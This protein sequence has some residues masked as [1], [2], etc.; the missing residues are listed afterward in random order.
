MNI[1][2]LKKF[3]IFGLGT[4]LIGGFCL[5]ALAYSPEVTHYPLA[6]EAVNLY[7]N[8]HPENKITQQQLLWIAE[9][10]H[11]EDRPASRA[12]HHFYDPVKNQ[13]LENFKSSKEWSHDAG[14]QSLNRYQ[15]AGAS[16]GIHTWEEALSAHKRG[17]VEHAYKTLG[18]IFH[19]IQDAT[20]PAHTRQD[21]HMHVDI[22]AY[23]V[24]LYGGSD[25]FEQEAKKLKI[26]SSKNLHPI[27]LDN[28][29]AYFDYVASY[30]NNNFWSKDTVGMYDLPKITRIDDGYVYSDIA[31][32][33][34]RLARIKKPNKLFD[35]NNP[36]LDDNSFADP[37]V[38]RDYWERL[39]PL[40]IES[41]AGIIKL[42]QDSVHDEPEKSKSDF[43]GGVKN[44]FSSINT[45]IKSR[46]Q[47]TRDAFGFAFSNIQISSTPVH[48][49]N[50]VGFLS[51]GVPL[52]YEVHISQTSK[53]EQQQAQDN[54]RGQVESALKN[55]SNT[56]NKSLSTRQA[57]NRSNTSNPNQSNTSLP[58]GQAGN[59]S[60]ESN[61][62]VTRILDGDTVEL[63]TGEHVRYIGV[64]APE[65]PEGCFSKEATEFNS[66]LVLN[67][68]VELTQGPD[69]KDNFGR[70]LRYVHV[71]GESINQKLIGTGHAYAFDYGF[72]H[73]LSEEFEKIE[74]EAKKNKR[75]L[76]GEVCHPQEN[77]S[78]IEITK[79]KIGDVLGDSTQS[80]S[81]YGP[82]TGRGSNFYQDKID[83]NKASQDENNQ[84]PEIA[85]HLVINE[86]QVQDAEFVELYNPTSKDLDLST[87]YFAYYPAS[88]TTWDNPYRLKK[89]PN[90][91]AISSGGYYLV[92]FNGYPE[93]GGNPSA[94]WQP[95]SSNQLNNSGATIALFDA[96]PE[97]SDI[98]P[99]DAVGW[100]SDIRVNLK[101]AITATA[102]G[103]GKSIS[104]DQEHSDSNNNFDDFEEGNPSPKNS[105]NEKS[106]KQAEIGDT[107][108]WS[109]SQNGGE[110]SGNSLFAGPQKNPSIMW[111]AEIFGSTSKEAQPLV[112]N[113]GNTYVA[114][115]G[116]KEGDFVYSLDI[117]G[118]I[119]WQYPGKG[120]LALS[121]DSKR[122]Y[123]VDLNSVITLDTPTGAVKN[124]ATV[125]LR[126]GY[127]MA[128]D[129]KKNMVYLASKNNLY[130]INE[131][132]SVAWK[133]N[134]S[135]LDWGEISGNPNA[136]GYGHVEKVVSALTYNGDLYV[137]VWPDNG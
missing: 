76:W 5:P 109:F 129:H 48:G 4:A 120:E 81:G 24:D 44:F 100:G 130:S 117:N 54:F 79:E 23:S 59:K 26:P 114:V 110:N 20:V 21:A 50:P 16:S 69:D 121:S 123:V 11:D 57:G 136:A 15:I 70:L 119:R 97:E 102:P 35:S 60:N 51:T 133:Q 9:G 90:G 108:L 85:Q 94:D 14:L 96:N 66:S 99:I 98:K 105:S 86:I 45:G 67:R 83:Q 32:K 22:G 95:Y 37:L 38:T 36:V 103:D 25:P 74:Q 27:Y 71:E 73:K 30:S 61:V 8:N 2:K 111:K 137:V 122:L 53:S 52:D 101:E 40:G 13:G 107:P 91:A 128:T 88:R 113:A 10:A 116:A 18:H 72:T 134:W 43:I 104:R 115:R 82:I 87:Y 132:G 28:I 62:V 34:H 125:D 12:T 118:D 7:N 46:W 126:G 31:D 89:F 47:S 29:D 80:N 39:A 77:K 1:D 49:D 131:A 63:N 41:T 78:P 56:S 75:G 6:E 68:E 3:I 55:R 127:R 93:S 64:N 17:D 112:D 84:E 19:L 58:T 135:F 33:E 106:E 92:G 65:S 42:F 124:N